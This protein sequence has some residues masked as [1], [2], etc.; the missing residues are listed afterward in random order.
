[1][2]RVPSGLSTAAVLHTS[3]K[4]TSGPSSLTLFNIMIRGNNASGERSRSKYECIFFLL[5][6]GPALSFPV[7]LTVISHTN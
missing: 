1:M 3:R 7:W 6:F 2:Y 4:H 5:T